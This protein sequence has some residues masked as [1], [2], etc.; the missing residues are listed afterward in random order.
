LCEAKYL[1]NQSFESVVDNQGL[2][3]IIFSNIVDSIQEL[4]DEAEPNTSM[5]LCLRHSI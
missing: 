1:F 2:K 4:I 5:P 3:I